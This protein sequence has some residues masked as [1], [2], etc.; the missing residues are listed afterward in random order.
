MSENDDQAFWLGATRI[1]IGGQPT[2][3]PNTG[4]RLESRGVALAPP[5]LGP[6]YVG[7]CIQYQD[8]IAA[9]EQLIVDAT[10]RTILQMMEL[11]LSVAQKD[12]RIAE[13]EAQ[14]AAFTAQP[15]PEPKTFPP[16][17]LKPSKSDPRRVG[18]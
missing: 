1:R 2:Y 7:L 10:N 3:D 6:D 5:S 15:T 9:L 16:A 14:L 17:A 18:G 8:R 4:I 12:K 11:N 13:L